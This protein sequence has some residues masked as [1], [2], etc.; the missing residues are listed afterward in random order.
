MRFVPIDIREI[1][2]NFECHGDKSTEL[3]RKLV[4]A[5]RELVWQSPKIEPAV[6]GRPGRRRAGEQLIAARDIASILLTTGTDRFRPGL[7]AVGGTRR[8]KLAGCYAPPLNDCLPSRQGKG[9]IVV[10]PCKNGRNVFCTT[11]MGTH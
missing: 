11:R 3:T 9:H 10:S 2:A 4:A 7:G 8:P 6:Q 5:G 1:S